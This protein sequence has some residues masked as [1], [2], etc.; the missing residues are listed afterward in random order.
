MADRQPILSAVTLAPD[1]PRGPNG[2]LGRAR[3]L[4]GAPVMS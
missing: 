2:R 3:I 4:A 1:E